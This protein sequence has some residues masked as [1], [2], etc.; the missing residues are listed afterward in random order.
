MRAKIITLKRARVLRSTMTEPEVMLWAR[1]RKRDPVWPIFRRQHAVG[2]YILD[3]Y[4]PAARLA[5]EVDGVGHGEDA[6]RAYDERRDAWLG[7][8]GITVY[9]VWA[10]SV[11]AD[12][13]EVADQVRRLADELAARCGGRPL[14]QPLFGG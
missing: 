10:S 6:R 5:V 1:L 12:A 14:R 4:C 11:F 13:D 2:S 7:A 3:F 9:R 8:R